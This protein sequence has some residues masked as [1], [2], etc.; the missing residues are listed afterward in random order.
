MLPYY[1][2][3]LSETEV[4]INKRESHQY[5]NYNSGFLIKLSMNQNLKN[6]SPQYEVD[7]QLNDILM[8]MSLIQIKAAMKLLA[9]QDLNAKYQLGLAK[10]YYVKKVGENEKINYIENYIEYFKAKYGP[11]KNEKQAQQIMTGLSQIEKGL[12]YEDIQVMREA[13][14]Y[15]MT[16]ENEVDKIDEEITKLQGGGGFWGFFSSG[17]TE[18]QKKQIQALQEKKNK[19]LKEN[20]D[21][22]V[23]ERLKK[24]QSGEV[25]TMRDIP[26]NFCLYRI[27]LKLPSFYMDINKQNDEKMLSTEFTNFSVTGEMRK[28]GQ[29]F[30][31]LIDDVTAK[32]NQLEDKYKM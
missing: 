2:Y 18:D 19:L 22:G 15:K 3:C 6:G 24:A 10:E 4:H 9:Y 21:K 1:R 17:P 25:D 27:L 8:S 30:N 26:D 31:L 7:C 32:Q 14:K 16:H 11:K 23:Q 28:K 13:A 12:K 29:L 20:V 5:L